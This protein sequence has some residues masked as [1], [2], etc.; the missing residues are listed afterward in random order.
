MSVND[1]NKSGRWIV[2]II[3]IMAARGLAKMGSSSSFGSRN[4]SPHSH[5]SYSPFGGNGS[6]SF[7]PNGDISVGPYLRSNGTIVPGHHRTPSDG[8][9]Q[10]NWSTYPNVNPHTGVQGS[11]R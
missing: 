9:Y 11:R 4:E 7:A 5:V 8:V 1:S 6:P 10:N 3:V 2:Y